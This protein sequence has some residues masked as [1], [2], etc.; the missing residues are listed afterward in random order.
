MNLEKRIKWNKLKYDLFLKYNI[1]VIS[2]ER[3]LKSLIFYNVCKTKEI[4]Y[5]L[6]NLKTNH[7]LWEE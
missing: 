3:I 4:Y 7:I 6:H 2:N 1:L 5:T